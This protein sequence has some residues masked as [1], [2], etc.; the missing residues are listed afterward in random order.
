MH[1]QR[2]VLIALIALVG[3][4]GQP[5]GASARSEL[6]LL[7]TDLGADR[8]VVVSAAHEYTPLVFSDSGDALTMLRS[9]GGHDELQR[10]SLTDGSRTHLSSQRLPGGSDP[11]PAVS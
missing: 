5:V 1:V 6:H 7:D 10:A 2:L 8:S 11:L 3:L 9:G 4:I